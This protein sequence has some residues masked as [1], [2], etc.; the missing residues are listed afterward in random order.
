MRF[1]SKKGDNVLF[2]FHERDD[3]ELHLLVE[4]LAG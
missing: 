3:G 1:N 2:S 4:A